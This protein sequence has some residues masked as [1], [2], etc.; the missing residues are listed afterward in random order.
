VVAR[1]VSRA[2]DEA[3]RVER[4]AVMACGPV[5]VVGVEGAGRVQADE[6]AE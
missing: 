4:V 3:S 5:T 2:S 1:R 6:G